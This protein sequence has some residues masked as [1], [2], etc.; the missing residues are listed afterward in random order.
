MKILMVLISHDQLGNMSK[1]TGFWLAE[2]AAPY[3]VFKDA[4]TD[5]TL[6]FPKGG[7]PPLDPKS[8]EPDAQTDAT[9]RFKNDA[10]SQRA[11]GDDA[12]GWSE[13][14]SVRCRVLP[15][16]PRTAVAPG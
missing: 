6:A 16:R 5:I 3:Y 4:G 7:K 14:G 11:G 2:F 1:K 8:D 12:A 10:D 9:R 15:G 13:G